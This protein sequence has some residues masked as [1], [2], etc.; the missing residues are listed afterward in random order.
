MVYP[1]PFSALYIHYE[2]GFD[3]DTGNAK[4][5]IPNDFKNTYI[6]STNVKRLVKQTSYLN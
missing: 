5:P 2:G 1:T 4:K 6:N 3:M